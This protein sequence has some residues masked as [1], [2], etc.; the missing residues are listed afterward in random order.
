MI[1]LRINP[2][3]INKKELKR[4]TH[5]FA[6]VLEQTLKQMKQKLEEDSKTYPAEYTIAMENGLYAFLNTIT[7][8]R[9]IDICIL[10]AHKDLKRRMN[11]N[12]ISPEQIKDENKKQDYIG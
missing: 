8:D 2:E 6:N 7:Q 1:D 12:A 9:T 10:L 3:D 5:N 4:I 11:R